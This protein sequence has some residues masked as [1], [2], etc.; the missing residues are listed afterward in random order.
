M[1]KIVHCGLTTTSLRGKPIKMTR[2]EERVIAF[3]P[4]HIV[5]YDNF[6][7]Y[8]SPYFG[9]TL[10]WPHLGQSF[11]LPLLLPST[12]QFM[13][14]EWQTIL[15]KSLFVL[16]S[17]PLSQGPHLDILILH[18]K[19]KLLIGKHNFRIL[20]IRFRQGIL[21]FAKFKAAFLTAAVGR[22]VVCELYEMESAIP[23]PE[24]AWCNSRSVE[25]F[26]DP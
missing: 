20:S 23:L 14:P 9:S 16:T 25:R 3:L 6:I 19:F 18:A 1:S 13:L 15:H 12:I 26:I 7:T 11:T 10:P 5:S 22:E 17:F 4:T 24:R 21:S 2:F 8:R